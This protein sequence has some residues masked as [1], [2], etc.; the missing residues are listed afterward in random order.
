MRFWFSFRI[1]PEGMAVP[2]SIPATLIWLRQA[3]ADQ[4]VAAQARH[5]G[6]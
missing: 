3:A 4:G 5:P 2:R 6:V 1:D